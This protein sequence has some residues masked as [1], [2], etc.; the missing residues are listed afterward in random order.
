MTAL[1]LLLLQAESA[2]QAAAEAVAFV[3]SLGKAEITFYKISSSP[4][5]KGAP[6]GRKLV[7]WTIHEEKPL[8]GADADAV[9]ATLADRSLYGDVAAQCFEPGLAFRFKG[10]GEPVDFVICLGCS[11]IWVYRGEDRQHTWVISKDGIAK[12]MALYKAH[13]TPEAKK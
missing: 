10:E 8:K 7:R 3:K 13:T 9:R 1:L 4:G 12:L 2:A 6:E 11:W 5:P